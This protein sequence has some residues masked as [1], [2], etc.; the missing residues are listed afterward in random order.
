MSCQVPAAK[1]VARRNRRAKDVY[2]MEV[3]GI[4]VLGGSKRKKREGRL[5][6]GVR[7]I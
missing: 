1:E 6:P 7:R 4:E 5:F 3:T 2:R